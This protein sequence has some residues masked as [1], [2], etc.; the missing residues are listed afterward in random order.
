MSIPLI[1]THV[2]SGK[3][4]CFT[5]I[6]AL[7]CTE[8]KG[9]VFEVCQVLIFPHYDWIR[10]ETPYLRILRIRALFTQCWKA[11]HFDIIPWIILSKEVSR[12]FPASFIPWL[13][14]F[15][16]SEIAC[17]LRLCPDS[18]KYPSSS[19]RVHLRW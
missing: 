8:W 10:R 14:F 18:L 6:L 19:H 16:L 11:I 15:E 9:F 13:V 2:P 3:P 7:P 5:S 4:L 12:M 1:D 17:L